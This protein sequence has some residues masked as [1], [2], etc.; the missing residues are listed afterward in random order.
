MNI[1][2]NEYIFLIYAL[3]SCLLNI[4]LYLLYISLD[5][6]GKVNKFRKT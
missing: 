5:V 4:E 2:I 1:N 3:I 6:H